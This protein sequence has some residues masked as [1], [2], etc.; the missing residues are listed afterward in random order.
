MHC[1]PGRKKVRVTCQPCV[2]GGLCCRLH[3]PGLK[4]AQAERML[5]KIVAVERN[6]TIK[7]ALKEQLFTERF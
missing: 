5:M 2:G 6:L 7:E 1:L 3:G 4:I